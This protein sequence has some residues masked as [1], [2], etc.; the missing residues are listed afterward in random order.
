M[1]FDWVLGWFVDGLA[2]RFGQTTVA[3]W[4]VM[5]ALLIL[6][7]VAVVAIANLAF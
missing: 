6:A 7:A 2:K 3:G 4:I 1:G 5:G